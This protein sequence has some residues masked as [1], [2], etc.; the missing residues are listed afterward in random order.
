MFCHRFGFHID[1][2]P[3]WT[4]KVLCWY[5]FSITTSMRVFKWLSL[6]KQIIDPRKT[7]TP[8]GDNHTAAARSSQTQRER[9]NDRT[10]IYD[11]KSYFSINGNEPCI[12]P[13]VLFKHSVAHF[14]A[15]Y[16]QLSPTPHQ[17][18]SATAIS[19]TKPKQFKKW[20]TRKAEQIKIASWQ[21]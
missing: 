17:I 11:G 14:L 1:P 16:G 5:R 12:Q 4:T 6:I 2:R 18:A 15:E 19:P 7:F 13:T 9:T 8:L 20:K 10:Q 21:G 3:I